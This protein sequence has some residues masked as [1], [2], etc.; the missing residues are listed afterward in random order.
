[1][2]VIRILILYSVMSWFQSFER[3]H[4]L[5]IQSDWIRCRWMLQPWRWRHNFLS[6]HQGQLIILHDI[7]TQ[8]TIT[9]A[10]TAM[11]IFPLVTAEISFQLISLSNFLHTQYIDD[12]ILLIIFVW[13]F[14][15]RN[16]NF[17]QR[18]NNFTYIELKT[19]FS[20]L[21]TIMVHKIVCCCST[22]L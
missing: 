21:W 4:Y 3:K 11:K 18:V 20:D 13:I 1:M 22:V 17:L 6:K 16:Y 15:N 12:N 7:K 10:T 19:Y 5:H 8:E 9:L 2:I 14:I